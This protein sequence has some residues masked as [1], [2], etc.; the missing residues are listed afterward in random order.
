MSSS[1]FSSTIFLFF[2]E[3]LVD[4]GDYAAVLIFT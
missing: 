1:S 3:F 4:K 2:T